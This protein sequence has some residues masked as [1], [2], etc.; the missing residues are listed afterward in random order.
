MQVRRT[1]AL[2][3]VVT[4]LLLLAGCGGAATPAPAPTQVPAAA[5]PT[6]APQAAPTTPPAAAQAPTQPPQAGEPA[7]FRIAVGI[8]PDNMDPTQITTVLVTNIVKYMAEA[9]VRIDKEGK[10]QPALATSWEISDD[11]LEYTLHLR[12]GVTFQDGTPFDA[13]AVKWNFDR[14]F[15]PAIE[16]RNLRNFQA[17]DKVEIV[18]PKTVKVLLKYPSAPM[19]GVLGT[20]LLVSPESVQAEGNS[21]DAITIP[22]GTGPYG[23]KERVAGERI[24]VARNESYWGEQPYYDQVV[25]QIVPEAATRESLLLAGQ[26]DMIVLPPISDVPALQANPDV[27]VLLVPTSRIVYIGINNKDADGVLTDARVRQALNYAVDKEAI[28]R[29]VLFNAGEPMENP[30]G[31]KLYGDCPQPPYDYNPEKARQ[32][33]AEAGHESLELGFISPT[34]RYVQDFPAAEAIAGYLAE[35]GVK[36]S[37]QTMDWPSYVGAITTPPEESSLDLHLLGWAPGFL[38]ASQMAIMYE[39]SF[40]V[41]NGLGTSF[42]ANPEVD[43]LLTA[44]LQEGDPAKREDLY[45]Q[46]SKIVWEEAPIIFLWVQHNPIVHQ[47][48]IT[49]VEGLPTEEFDAIYARPA[50]AQ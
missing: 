8:D 49:N 4:I 44:A 28:I 20:Y 29:S 23:F 27:K 22:V 40:Q 36:T 33:L 5:A 11:G 47:A 45:C 3:G 41:P 34:G 39:S 46:A 9:L 35:I 25:F 31:A 26:V 48:N 30:I 38:D 43:E 15:D 12:E 1:F 7:T 13:E 10:A 17:I 18:D 42:Y 6:E 32:L 19:L 50:S 14:L 2:V 21:Y 24:V 37:L 16:S